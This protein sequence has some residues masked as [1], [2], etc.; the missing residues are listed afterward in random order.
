M[1]R[2]VLGTAA[3]ALLGMLA[4]VAPPAQVVST[5]SAA[6]TQRLRVATYNVQNVSVD[7]TDGN[8]KPW[9]ERRSSVVNTI[10]KQRPD[11]LGVQETSP[12]RQTYASRYVDGATQFSDLRDGLND[13]GGDYRVTDYSSY[14]CENDK[15]NYKCEPENQGATGAERILYN[16][17]TVRMVSHGGK[18]YS[19]QQSGGDKR[20]MAWAVFELKSN[21]SKFF[22]ANTHLHKSPESVL[23]AQWRQLIG[24]VDD[25]AG[26]LPVVVT[27]DFNTQKFSPQA[28]EMLPAMKRAG[29]GDVLNQEFEDTTVDNPRARRTIRAW[30]SSYN[31]LERSIKRYSAYTAKHKVWNSIDWIFASNRLAVDSYELVINL[32]EPALEVVGTIPSDHFMVRADLLLP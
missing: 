29:W 27:G 19:T 22:F 17:D 4:A 9:R 13:K 11:V 25:L 15:T 3:L 12:S 8:Q 28:E 14:N 30:I 20:Y 24:W 26:D 2:P 10:W 16:A 32:D 18:K 23:K 21:G 7:K 6:D 31:Y 5:A 1:R